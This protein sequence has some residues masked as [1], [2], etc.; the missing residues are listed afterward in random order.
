MQQYFWRMEIGLNGRDVFPNI[1]YIHEL[2]ILHIRIKSNIRRRSVMALF[3]PNRKV[4][5]VIKELQKS[6]A[7]PEA[8]KTRKSCYNC[9][10]YSSIGNCNF[11]NKMMHKADYCGNYWGK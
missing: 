5:K 11:H 2:F 1:A 4:K 8:Y 7:S 9:K 10:Y 3:D 6:G